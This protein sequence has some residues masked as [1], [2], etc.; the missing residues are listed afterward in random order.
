MGGGAKRGPR[1][2]RVGVESQGASQGDVGQAGVPK[3]VPKGSG[4]KRGHKGRPTGIWDGP[5]LRGQSQGA[6][7]SGRPGLPG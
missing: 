6:L 2:L 5:G 1:G 7:G 4:L 3:S